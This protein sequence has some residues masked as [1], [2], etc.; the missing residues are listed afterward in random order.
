MK[1]VL[2]YTLLLMLVSLSSCGQKQTKPH[3]YNIN[4]NIKDSITSQVPNTMVR[5]VRQA[6]N[7]DILIASCKGV[8]RYDGK[9]F[10]NITSGIPS[11][12][13]WD[14]LEDRKGN[15]WFA[16]KDSGVYYYNARLNDG[17]GQGQ[18]PPTGQAGF[19][20]FTTR[21]GLA[22]NTALQ[23][24]E[25]RA[26]NIWFSTSGGVSRYDGK[27]FRNFTTEDG[28]PNN[29]V[30]TIM[31][32]KTGKLWIGTTGDACIYDG[33]TFTTL[34]NKDGNGFRNV[35]GIMQDK[36]GSI[37]FGDVEGLWRY[38]DNDFTKISQRGVYG[39]IEDKKGNIWTTGPVNAP[40]GRV[41]ALSRYDAKSLYDKMPTVTEIKSGGPSLLGILEANDGSIWFGALGLEIGV[42]R[43][44]GK[45]LTHFTSKEAQQ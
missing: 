33:K 30:H 9:S 23:I 42:H 11:P 24:C 16:S 12:C 38:T 32:D 20:H 18:S 26:G 45:T 34:T 21:D 37:W 6:S 36:K 28:L 15:L 10:T 19:Q 31:E 27:S 13:F 40:D 14:V 3:K 1:Y 8:F 4:N 41:S 39:I 22:S 35:W 2:I 43:Y 7:G 5:N 29:G 44:D 25:D 17:V